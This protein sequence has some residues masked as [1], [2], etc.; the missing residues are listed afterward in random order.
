M[1]AKLLG[2]ENQLLLALSELLILSCVS[3][4]L[5]LELLKL[6]SQLIT[7]LTSGLDLALQ[8]FDISV[9]VGDPAVRRL[10]LLVTLTSLIARGSHCDLL[11]LELSVKHIQ[12]A[13]EI[14]VCRSE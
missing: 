1:I 4:G 11:Y 5:R 8:F 9:Q 13:F 6:F 2:L 14:F 7:F 12:I 10:E 3:S